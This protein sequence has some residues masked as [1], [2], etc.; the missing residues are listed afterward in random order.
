MFDLSGWEKADGSNLTEENFA[1]SPEL[2]AEFLDL[3]K[4]KKTGFS[5]F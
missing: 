4:R 2:E 5:L 3:M 1:V